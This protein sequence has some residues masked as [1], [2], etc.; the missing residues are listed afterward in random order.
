MAPLEVVPPDR[1][2]QTAVDHLLSPGRVAHAACRHRYLGVPARMD[3]SESDIAA[4]PHVARA[5]DEGGRAADGHASRNQDDP[6]GDADGTTG[7]ERTEGFVGRVAGD[8][9]GYAEETGAEARA[10]E[11]TDR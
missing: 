7:T 6:D 8:E 10:E 1:P 3:R 2:A 4:D 5:R 11:G 9:A